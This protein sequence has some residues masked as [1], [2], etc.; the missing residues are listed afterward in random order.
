VHSACKERSRLLYVSAEPSLGRSRRT[1]VSLRHSW[2][3][4]QITRSDSCSHGASNRP[5]VDIRRDSSPGS[6]T[7]E[8]MVCVCRGRLHSGAAEFAKARGKFEYLSRDRKLN[9][10]MADWNHGTPFPRKP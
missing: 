2:T 3:W 4:E 9:P 6:L 5:P 1:S 7:L 8:T 10:L